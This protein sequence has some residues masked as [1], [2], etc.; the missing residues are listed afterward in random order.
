MQKEPRAVRCALLNGSTWSTEK[1][2]MRRYRGTFDI[3]FGVKHRMR[4]EEIEEQF[5]KEA[6]QEWRFAGSG[7]RKQSGSSC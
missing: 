2:Y 5:N 6:K 4:K 1:K 3:F 7:D